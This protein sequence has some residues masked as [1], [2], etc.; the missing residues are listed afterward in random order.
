MKIEN[1]IT[2]SY[3]DKKLEWDGN[4]SLG[5]HKSWPNTTFYYGTPLTNVKNCL[6]E[7]IH[8]INKNDDV[9]VSVE[10]NTAFAQAAL[11]L[12]INESIINAPWCDRAVI[13]LSIPQKYLKGHKLVIENDINTRLSNNRLYENWDKSDVEYYALINVRMPMF[14]PPE[15]IIGYMVR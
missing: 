3:T 6:R 1:L 10:P 4:P 2:E 7:G 8:P 13:Q 11:S 5:W 9:I 15:Y 12:Q 14:I